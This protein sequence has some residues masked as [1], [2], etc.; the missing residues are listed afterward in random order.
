[1]VARYL[2]L[3]VNQIHPVGVYEGEWVTM[4][5]VLMRN[6]WTTLTNAHRECVDQFGELLCYKP[7]L[8][9]YDWS[10]L[11]IVARNKVCFATLQSQDEAPLVTFDY[12]WEDNSARMCINPG[13]DEQLRACMRMMGG[14]YACVDNLLDY[15]VLL[16]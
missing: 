15:I 5:P 4:A 3:R 11:L 9:W 13:D 16:E 2:W 14:K 1:M 8:T 10:R 6:D 7:L 12:Q